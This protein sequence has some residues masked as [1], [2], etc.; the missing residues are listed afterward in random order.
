MAEKQSEAIIDLR[1]VQEML[2][3]K[4]G[5]TRKGKGGDYDFSNR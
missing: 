1:A 5:S 2:F 4:T 3:L